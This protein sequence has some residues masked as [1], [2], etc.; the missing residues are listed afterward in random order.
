MATARMR[1]ARAKLSTTVS[2]ETYQF[3]ENKVASGEAANIAEAVDRSISLVREVENRERL[4]L[5]TASYFDRLEPRAA[6]EE[7]SLARDLTS[8]GAGV[9]F[10]QEL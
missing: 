9:D 1:L 4:A 10:D 2:R 5:A 7:R 3:L 8:A 6:A